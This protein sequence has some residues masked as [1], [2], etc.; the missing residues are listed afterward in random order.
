[1]AKSGVFL[2]ATNTFGIP[3]RHNTADWPPKD[4]K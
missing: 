3:D 2:I 1:M 4:E